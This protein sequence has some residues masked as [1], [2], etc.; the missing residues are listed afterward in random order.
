MRSALRVRPVLER[1]KEL[2]E[3]WEGVGLKLERGGINKERDMEGSWLKT[4]KSKPSG[5]AV[6]TS[7]QKKI[8]K[9]EF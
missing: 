7:F 1:F 9:K 2:K 4:I 5:S 6:A 3:S 8:S